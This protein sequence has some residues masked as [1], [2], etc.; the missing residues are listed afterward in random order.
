MGLKVMS[1]L[2]FSGILYASWNQTKM[3]LKEH[4]SKTYFSFV[5]RVEIRPKWDWKLIIETS[6]VLNWIGLKSDQNGIES[7]GLLEKA[8]TQ[9]QIVEIRPKWDW[10]GYLCY[11]DSVW[12]TVLKSDQ[13]GIESL[14]F[15]F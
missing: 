7:G 12:H 9:K 11:Y 1:Y 2:C 14:K 10:K 13:N 15:I 6:Q 4:S 5:G 8:T 3:G